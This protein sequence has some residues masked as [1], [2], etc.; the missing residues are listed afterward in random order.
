MIIVGAL[1]KLEPFNNMELASRRN[2]VG[3]SLIGSICETQEVLDF[4]AEHNITPDIELIPIQ[5]I[6]D[7]YKKV[8]DGE[9]RFRY[10][11][12]MKSLAKDSTK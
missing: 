11:I 7:A 8:E 9:F 10:V 3:G 2:T 1:E 5:D 6:N 12:D 4:C